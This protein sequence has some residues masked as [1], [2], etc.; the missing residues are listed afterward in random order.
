MDLMTQKQEDQQLTVIYLSLSAVLFFAPFVQHL[1]WQWHLNITQQQQLFVQWYIRYGYAMIGLLILTLCISILT[2]FIS[3]DVL[4][5]IAHIGGIAVIVLLCMGVIMVF[6]GKVI[7]QSST[8][9]ITM[10]E[11]TWSRGDIIASYLPWYNIRLRYKL[12]HSDHPY[13]W[14]KESLLLWSLYVAISLVSPSIIIDNIALLLVLLRVVMLVVGID[15]ISHTIKKSLNTLFMKHIEELWAYPVAVIYYL[16]AKI[17]RQSSDKEYTDYVSTQ[18]T[19]YQTT[20][21]RSNYQIWLEYLIVLILIIISII[22]LYIWSVLD[23]TMFV[24]YLPY[25]LLL[26]FISIKIRLNMMS[27]LPLIHECMMIF[28]WLRS[29]KQSEHKDIKAT[30]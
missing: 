22:H 4:W 18:K 2:F 17:T 1:L 28:I 26:T 21:V 13:R 14:L 6:M 5:W 19:I 16:Y 23:I 3:Y 8:P 29:K 12:W 30:E 7:F 11:V 24:D 20:V 10:E 25:M 27:P 9:M 15:I